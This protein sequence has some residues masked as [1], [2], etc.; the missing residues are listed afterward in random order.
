MIRIKN[1]TFV[2]SA[3]DRTNF[4]HGDKPQIAV[5]GKSNVGKSTFINF[6]ANNGKLARTSNTPGRTRL[7]NYFDFGEFM[8][9]DLPGYGFAK[10]SKEEQARWGV[11]LEDYLLEE[12]MLKRVILLVDIRHA[13]TPED[14]M[15]VDFLY[16]HTIS[17]SVIA[18]KEDKLKKSEIKPRLSAIAAALGLGIGNIFS[19]SGEKKTGMD[20]VLALLSEALEPA[21]GGK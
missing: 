19:V 7:V 8:L 17:F 21:E 6:L 12:P 3:S 2:K 10:A 11:F 14:R 16:A 18:T 15:L 5:A 20:K 13:P 1:A 9:V 4:W